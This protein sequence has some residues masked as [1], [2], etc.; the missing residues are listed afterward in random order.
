MCYITYIT[1]ILR[2]CVFKI[3]QHYLHSEGVCFSKFCNITYI[4]YILRMCVFQNFATLHT[5]PTLPTFWGRVFLKIVLHYSHYLHY[6]YSKS[7]CFQ[8]LQHYLHYLHSEVVCFSKFC[9]ITYI[10]YITYILRV[11][12]FK[13]WQHYLHSEGMC[14]SKILLHY[15]HYIHALF[16]IPELRGKHFFRIFQLPT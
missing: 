15:I 1:Y 4:T 2:V 16:T 11:C 3:L 10:T 13:I 6:L 5:L 14:F 9:Y 12:V 7:V 8:I